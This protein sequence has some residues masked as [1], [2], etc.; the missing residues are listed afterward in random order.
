MTVDWGDGNQ[1]A[2]TGS[3]SR[4]H[5][6]AT[7]GTYTV[8]FLAPLLVTVFNISDAKVTLNSSQIKTISNVTD[9]RLFSIL[10]GSFNSTD[11]SAWRP[12]NFYL[13]SMPSGYTGTFNSADVSAWRPAYFQ[14][15]SMSSGYAVTI[16]AGGF[17]AWTTTTSLSMYNDA[18]T[19]AQ[20]NQILTDCYTAFPSR[21]ATGGTITLNG[22]GN[23]APSG[24]FQAN[25]P[26]TSG[27]ET[28][29]DLL[30]DPCS[31]NPTHKWS[32]ITTN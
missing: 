20:V 27:K 29:Y 24:I 6:Y 22:T 10:A 23:A 31:V 25:C 8:Q 7:A 13:I 26:P 16:T 19:Q 30:N 9:F 15:G 2:Y 4:T 11:V 3:G 12:T 21:T 18:L 5:T 28:A 32:T 17:S 1:N 14:L